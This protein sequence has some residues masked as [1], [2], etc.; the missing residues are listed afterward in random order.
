MSGSE[1]FKKYAYTRL[2]TN[3]GLIE[4]FYTFYDRKKIFLNGRIQKVEGKNYQKEWMFSSQGK[5]GKI[6]N[7]IKLRG[8][9]TETVTE[10]TNFGKLNKKHSMKYDKKTKTSTK[11]VLINSYDKSQ[12][13]TKSIEKENDQTKKIIDYKYEGKY[14]KQIININNKGEENTY[15]TFGYDESGNLIHIEMDNYLMN[16]QYEY[17]SF[18]NWIFK[19]ESSNDGRINE[20]KRKIKYKKL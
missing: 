4:E 1:Q 19:R 2:Q 8:I 5:V 20:Y 18:G 6:K 7:V 14:L 12:K 11:S 3:Q 16:I 13:L 15:A 9:T 10:Y 17:D